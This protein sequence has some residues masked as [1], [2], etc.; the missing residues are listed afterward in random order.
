VGGNEVKL[1]A[2]AMAGGKGL[3]E[4]FEQAKASA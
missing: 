3:A 1:E 4:V 2:N